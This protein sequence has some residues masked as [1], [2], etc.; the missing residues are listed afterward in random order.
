MS[1]YEKLWHYVARQAGDSLTMSFGEIG[2]AAG[3]ALDHSFLRA[4]KELAD[5]GWE[6]KKI[7]MKEQRVLFKKISGEADEK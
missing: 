7:S 2:E 4:K 3:V 1:K 6:V 5:F